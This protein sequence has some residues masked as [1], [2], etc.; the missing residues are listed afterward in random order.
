MPSRKYLKNL[1]FVDASSNK[2]TTQAN[3]GLNIGD[4]DYVK[5]LSEVNVSNN[6]ITSFNCAGFQGILDLRNNK[7]TN[8]RLENSK[9]GSQVVSL[10]LDGNS[11]SKTPSIDF[12]PEWIAVLL[13]NWRRKQATVHMKLLKHGI[14]VIWLTQ[15]SEKITQIM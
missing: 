3:A 13:T 5:S 2:F 10:Y 4:T 15:S 9:E 7:I 12:T 14:M 1:D 6:A 8:L 11:L